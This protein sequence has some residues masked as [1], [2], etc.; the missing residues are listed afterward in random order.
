M[1]EEAIAAPG[2]KVQAWGDRAGDGTRQV[3]IFRLGEG[4]EGLAGRWVPEEE[5]SALAADLEARG[6]GLAEHDSCSGFL[7]VA[8]DASIEVY[9][10][11][12]KELTATGDEATIANGRVIP[13]SEI[14][15]VIAFRSDDYVSRGVKAV[16]RSGE[17]VGLVTEYSRA[18]MYDPTY[19]WL[20]M[21]Q[22]TLWVVPIGGAIASWAGAPFENR[23]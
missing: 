10:R 14:A 3:V 6:I 18:A 4:S 22:E 12:G 7:S 20:L 16:L 11:E 15:T 17:E 23:L 5:R 2:R 8:T 21:F 19:D 9:R 13:R 1:L